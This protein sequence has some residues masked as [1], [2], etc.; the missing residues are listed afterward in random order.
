MMKI[1]A[2]AALLAALSFNV[3]QAD[4]ILEGYSYACKRAD[5]LTDLRRA[6]D[7][8]DYNRR[9]YLIGTRACY[10]I[11]NAAAVTVLFEQGEMTHFR[12]KAGQRPKLWTWS[13]NI[14]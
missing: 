10:L 4:R 14:R 13:H 3:A 5:H 1:P 6:L 11:N 12:A 2:L 8:A 9:D 7:I